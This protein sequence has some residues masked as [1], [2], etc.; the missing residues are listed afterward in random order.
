MVTSAQLTAH[1]I[2]EYADVVADRSVARRTLFSGGSGVLSGG[3]LDPRVGLTAGRASSLVAIAAAA[4]VA[5]YSPGA[6]VL[7]VVAL[8]VSWGY[9][10]PPIR[11][12]ATGW[13]ELATSLVVAFLVP[14]I[15]SLALGGRLTAALVWIVAV[16]VPIHVTMMLAFEIPDLA[17]DAAAGKN[18]LAVRIGLD[19]TVLVMAVL[20]VGAGLV[21]AAG[22][23]SRSVSADALVGVSL[24]AVPGSITILLARQQRPAAL[25]TAAVA[26]LVVA[27]LALAVGA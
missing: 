9:S 26:T 23:V 16:L 10:M 14:L 19:R 15:A 7:G 4:T 8:A 11:L 12:L 17:T 24:A 18:V 27:A 25:T 2:N 5:T 20:L 1:Y 22:W 13:G 6:A 21:A 3:L